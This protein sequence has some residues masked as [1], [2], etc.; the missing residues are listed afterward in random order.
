M[1][2]G[3]GLGQRFMFVG[4]RSDLG[5]VYP[6]FDIFVLPSLTEA[7]PMALLE[8]MAAGLPVVATTVGAVPEII[9]NS[10]AGALV[11]PGNSDA[12]AEGIRGF[13]LSHARRQQV[14]AQARMRI[15]AR[16]SASTMAKEYVNLYQQILL[17][18]T[19][20]EATTFRRPA[21]RDAV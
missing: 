18:R 6:S 12:L 15:E 3:L 4:E 10:N 9:G 14:G 11:E 7:M 20:R 5:Q 21:R 19:G 2:H 17:R 1:A 13:L 16:F 8:A